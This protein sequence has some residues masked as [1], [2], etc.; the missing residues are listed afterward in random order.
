MIRGVDI[1]NIQHT[2]NWAALKSQGIRFAVI[3]CTT[4]NDGK[5]SDFDRHVAEAKAAGIAVGL[6]HFSFPLPNDPAHPGRSPAEQA[7]A[8]WAASGGLG[9]NDGELPP[10][11]DFEWPTADLWAKYPGCTPDQMRAHCLA[12]CEEFSQRWGCRPLVYTYPDWWM[13]IGGQRAPEFARNPLWMA[14]YPAGAAAWPVDG[15]RPPIVVKPWLRA[16]MWQFSGG[17]LVLPGVGKVDTDV[18]PDEATF[19]RLLT[20]GLDADWS[21]AGNPP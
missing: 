13:R 2:E 14:S 19:Q 21:A 18:V 3:K 9:S 20:A 4:G 12:A 16:S 6:Y 5:D 15:Q 17:G 7:D 8:C 1:S 10:A 11:L